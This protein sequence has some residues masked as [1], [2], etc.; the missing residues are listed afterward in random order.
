MHEIKFDGYRTQAHLRSGRPAMYTRRGHDW[1]GRYRTIAAALATLPA[2]DL[3]LDG[4]AVVADSGGFP[5]FRLLHADLAAGRQDRLL[6]YAFDLVYLDGLDL[7][8][9]ARR[10]SSRLRCATSSTISRRAWRSVR[11]RVCMSADVARS[12][13]QG[14][15]AIVIGLSPA[16]RDCDRL[17]L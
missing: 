11:P 17:A 3:V 10:A 13:V 5:D 1:T 16:A 14:P 2:Q 15:D 4:E 8:G 12:R 9:P 7:R 6:Y